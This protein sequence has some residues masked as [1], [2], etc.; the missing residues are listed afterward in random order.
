M[1]DEIDISISKHEYI[2]KILQHGNKIL[3]GICDLKFCI[4]DVKFTF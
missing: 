3:G 1:S 2:S 4:F